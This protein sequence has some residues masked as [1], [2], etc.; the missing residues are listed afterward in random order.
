[1]NWIE[2]CTLRP[3]AGA[4]AALLDGAILATYILIV[5]HQSGHRNGAR[6][7]FVVIFL[8]LII[9]LALV[10][11]LFGR[12]RQ[13]ISGPAFLAAGTGNVGIGLLAIFSIGLPLILLGAALLRIGMNQRSGLFS[14]ILAAA[15]AI[16]VLALGV[17]LTV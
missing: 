1:M 17:I 10:G 11:A 12:R 8:S 4:A 2:R 3:S 7:D 9:I 13:G 15:T 14:E 16:A 6:I 5:D